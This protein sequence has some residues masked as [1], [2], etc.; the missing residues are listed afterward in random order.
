[1]QDCFPRVREMPIFQSAGNIPLPPA[2]FLFAIRWYAAIFCPLWFAN[3]DFA[4]VAQL[5]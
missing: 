2:L 4:S 1:M 5:K 3:V